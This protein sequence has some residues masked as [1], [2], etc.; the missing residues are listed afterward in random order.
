[1]NVLAGTDSDGEGHLRVEL[2][3]N[4]DDGDDTALFLKEMVEDN[5]DEDFIIDLAMK[6]ALKALQKVSTDQRVS[7]AANS[8]KQHFNKFGRK[9]WL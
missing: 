2:S 8:L 6:A 9:L 1:M 5:D 3:V 4:A 7:E